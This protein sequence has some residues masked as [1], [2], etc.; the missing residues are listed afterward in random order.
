MSGNAGGR[1]VADERDDGRVEIGGDAGS[2]RIEVIALAGLPEVRASDDLGTMIG[3]P[4]HQLRRIRPIANCD[5][6]TREPMPDGTGRLLA[7]V[8]DGLRTS[9]RGQP[10]AVGRIVEPETG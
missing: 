2:G 7:T 10:E 3:M 8:C 6:R 9:W 4:F 1:R 5:P